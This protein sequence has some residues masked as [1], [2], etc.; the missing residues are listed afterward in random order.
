MQCTG[1]LFCEYDTGLK[2]SYPN[3]GCHH[4]PNLIPAQEAA[5]KLFLFVTSALLRLFTNKKAHNKMVSTFQLL[6]R[7]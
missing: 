7:C 2:L 1:R 5:Q 3:L 6:V 4:R